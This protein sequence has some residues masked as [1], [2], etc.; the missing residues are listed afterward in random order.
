MSAIAPPPLP[1]W[2]SLSL[3]LVPT[4]VEAEQ[5][6]RMV[7]TTPWSWL[8]STMAALICY[9][10]YADHPAGAAVRW[11]FAA[12]GA[13]VAVRLVLWAAWMRRRTQIAFWVLPALGTTLAM[14]ALWGVLS[15]LLDVQGSPQAESILHITLA[16]VA[17]GGTARMACFDRAL[18]GYVVLILGPTV[19]R[20]LLIGGGYHWLMAFLLFLIGVYGLLNCASISR[21]LRE[22]QTQR[23]RNA[24]LV[25]QLRQEAGRS[26]AAHQQAVQAGE[27][28]TRFF[29]A[30]NHDLR[31]PLHA[32]GLLV[33]TLRSP[34]TVAPPLP[35]MAGR[36]ADCV[37]G[38]TLVIDGLLD[39]SRMDA[40]DTAPQW[41]VF[42][43]DALVRECCAP[44]RIVA[45]AQGLAFSTDTAPVQV[46]S[47][48][49][50]LARVLANLVS[51]AIRYTP[52]GSVRVVAHVDGGQVRLA[53]EDTGIGIAPEHLPKIF[54]AFYQVGNPGRD[55]RL[56]LGLGLSTVQ[57][58]G[59][60][61]SLELAVRSQ[62][63]KGSVF[64]LALPLVASEREDS[65]DV[66]DASAP[67]PLQGR[68]V[69]VVDDD[70]DSR[71]AMVHLLASW[72]CAARGASD[73]A[74]GLALVADGFAPEA[75]VVDLRLANGASGID[76]V[77][78]LQAAAGRTLPALI[79]TGDAGSAHL[80]R[81]Q[82]AGLQVCVKPVRPVQLR[83]FLSQ[84]FAD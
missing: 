61:L 3:R 82:A 55:R 2:R 1:R 28:K 45:Q 17:L 73:A 48:R 44:L 6:E 57:R 9:L 15:I 75:L 4:A 24:E 84:V 8:L 58:I 67:S 50:L 43:L 36:L 39:M 63:G 10:Q 30:A 22:V 25:E 83:A 76:A 53:V 49:V 7:R 11:W 59:A 31:Q 51:N 74:A 66:A 64:A 42:A 71:D 33:H 60:L 20:D 14:G 72:A 70:A 5:L 41:S 79:V 27:A 34:G 38:M 29:A 65:V 21:A 77:Q 54:D 13:L 12:Y 18:L 35:D 56:G 37:D 68:R 23:K 78:A 26:A 32:M 80:Q 16:C 69:L 52:Q 40:G 46:R 47:D 81:A 19:V 62:P